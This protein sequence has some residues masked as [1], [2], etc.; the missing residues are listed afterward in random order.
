MGGNVLVV[1][2]NN[3]CFCKKN[4]YNS[5]YVGNQKKVFRTV[6]P[7]ATGRAFS[8]NSVSLK[9]PLVKGAHEI[10]TKQT[11]KGCSFGRTHF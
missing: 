11:R 8:E 6:K 7:V 9:L 1:L 2:T 3:G 5:M 10:K 4:P